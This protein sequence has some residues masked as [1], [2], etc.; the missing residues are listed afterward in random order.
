MQVSS[1]AV[2][3]LFLGTSFIA[4]PVQNR[5]EVF[6]SRHC[7][8]GN[9]YH[10]ASKL[11]TS[12]LIITQNFNMIWTLFFRQVQVFIARLNGESIGLSAW[13][14]FV[15]DLSAIL[16]VRL[17]ITC[18]VTICRFVL[19]ASAAVAAVAGAN[20]VDDDCDTTF[21][22]NRRLSWLRHCHPSVQLGDYNLHTW[23]QPSA[24]TV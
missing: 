18:L 12:S 14:L 1:D 9:L 13:G 3:C 8:A 7:C 24:R 15:L 23:L 20:D 16:R 4:T 6:G 19:L 17:S 2:D 5:L 11:I 22:D 10:S 21:S